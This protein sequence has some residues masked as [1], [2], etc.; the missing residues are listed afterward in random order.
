MSDSNTSEARIA[1]APQS[2]LLSIRNGARL[3]EMH[4]DGT[5]IEVRGAAPR[6]HACL[7]LRPHQRARAPTHRMGQMSGQQSRIWTRT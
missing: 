1:R 2:G 6:G 7:A 5:M 3:V 4:G